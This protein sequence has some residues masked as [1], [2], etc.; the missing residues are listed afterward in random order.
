MFRVPN[1]DIAKV[2]LDLVLFYYNMTKNILG[3]RK[4]KE[5]LHN[6]TNYEN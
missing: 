5:L 3:E 1:A 6:N 4:S 2:Y